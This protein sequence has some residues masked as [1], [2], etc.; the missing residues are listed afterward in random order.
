M[1]R[2]LHSPLLRR[3][4]FAELLRPRPQRE[5]PEVTRKAGE[6]LTA[7]RREG[8]PA[9]RRIALQLGDWRFGEPF[10]LRAP[11]LRQ[12]LESL[13]T[14]QRELLER[15]AARVRSFAQLQRDALQ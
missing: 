6:I 15:T 2:S 9:L 1:S 5:D 11:A 8:E 14:E 4:H 3:A 13:P 12:V 7:V 10:L